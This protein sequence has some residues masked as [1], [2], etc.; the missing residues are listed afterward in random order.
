MYYQLYYP[1]TD[2]VICP[3]ETQGVNRENWFKS[4]YGIDKVI[5]ELMGCGH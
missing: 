4:D 2:F 3:T 5:G 1:K